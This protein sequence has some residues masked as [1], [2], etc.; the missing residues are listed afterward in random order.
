M[1]TR[2][3]LEKKQHGKGEQSNEKEV[4]Q[5]PEMETILP[6]PLGIPPVRMDALKE[7]GIKLEQMEARKTRQSWICSV[8]LFNAA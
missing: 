6:D 1:E 3:P 4:G 5:K 8:V 2:F 7:N